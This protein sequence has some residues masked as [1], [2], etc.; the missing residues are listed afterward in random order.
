M[1]DKE[2]KKVLKQLPTQYA[3]DVNGFDRDRLRGEIIKSEVALHEV[4]VAEG[5]DDELTREKEKVKELAGPYRDA[6]KAQTA[7]IKYLLHLLEERGE[8]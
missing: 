3:D 7:K 6:K 2:L 4:R 5:N 8:L 1:T